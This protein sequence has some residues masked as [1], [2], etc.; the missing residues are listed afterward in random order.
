M[1]NLYILFETSSGTIIKVSSTEIEN[2]VD[3]RKSFKVNQKKLNELNDS[4]SI[5]RLFT[6]FKVFT[7]GSKIDLVDQRVATADLTY[8]KLL[9]IPYVHRS[10]DVT[11]EIKLEV[12][13]LENKPVLKIKFLGDESLKVNSYKN[14][15]HIHL[16]GKND[17]NCHY[18]TFELDL[19]KFVSDEMIY[20]IDRC[21]YKKLF[22]NQISFYHRKKLNIVYTIT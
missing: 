2:S 22:A 14:K 4:D 10:Q 12:T 11:A 1:D 6:D 3:T 17:I 20:D 7:N 16:T 15:T 13:S 21:D 19:N 8:N 18:Q 5:P 9:S